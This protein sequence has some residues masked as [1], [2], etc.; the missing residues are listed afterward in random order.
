[1]LF[2][3]T[4]YVHNWAFVSRLLHSSYCFLWSEYDAA[5]GALEVISITRKWFMTYVPVQV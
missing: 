5:R 2:I 1:M 4:L 3:R